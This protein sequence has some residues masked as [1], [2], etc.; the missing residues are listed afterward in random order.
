MYFSGRGYIKV[1]IHLTSIFPKE[2]PTMWFCPTHCDHP[3]TQTL[4]KG[5][6]YFE[7]SPKARN[8]LEKKT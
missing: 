8:Y 7:M 6:L 5:S 4:D 2:V 3:L 1:C